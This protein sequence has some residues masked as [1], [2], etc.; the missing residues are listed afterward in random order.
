MENCAVNISTLAEISA[1][2]SSAMALLSLAMSAMALIILIYYKLYHLFIYRLILYLFVSFLID[3]LRDSVQLPG[4]LWLYQYVQKE[5]YVGHFCRFLFA[6]E[7]YSMWN[8]Q[9]FVTLMTAELFSMT[10]LSVEL[11]KAE[12]LVVPACFVLPAIFPLFLL[13]F[14]E[15]GKLQWCEVM[16]NDNVTTLY[17]NLQLK[18]YNAIAE[19]GL[20][21]TCLV[22]IM[23]VMSYLAC[24]SIQTFPA[25]R[26]S[27]RWYLLLENRQTYSK[28]LR[29]SCPFAIYPVTILLT[30]LL[31]YFSF[32]TCNETVVALRTLVGVNVGNIASVIF[33][34]HIKTLGKRRRNMFRRRH[35]D[36]E[37]SSFVRRF[38]E[39][40]KFTPIGSI[41]ATHVTD[42]ES[43]GES[44]LESSKHSF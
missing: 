11:K 34:I 20:A 33:F 30:L 35:N 23:T 36:A 31:Y 10:L 7:L 15:A 28:A 27:E 3:G 29:E 5:A 44:D 24:R 18:K 43:P 41:T 13:I 2:I 8:V 37:P 14:Y 17:T 21:V 6:V 42:F 16:T 4:V 22:A 39:R 1:V 25:R 32:T 12:K 9:L 38:S 40:Q 26:N 19:I